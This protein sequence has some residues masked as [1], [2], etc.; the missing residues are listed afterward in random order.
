LWTADVAVMNVGYGT[1]PGAWRYGIWDPTLEDEDHHK[2]VRI[3]PRWDDPVR[4]VP[5]L[6]TTGTIAVTFPDKPELTK[7]ERWSARLREL[8]LEARAKERRVVL[9]DR[10]YED[11]E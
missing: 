8:Q 3:I 11:W 6:K 9:V 5:F 10:E 7:S 4:D 2:R 1:P